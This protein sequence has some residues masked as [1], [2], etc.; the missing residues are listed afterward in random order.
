MIIVI[1]SHIIDKMPDR[2]KNLAQPTGCLSCQQRFLSLDIYRLPFRLLLPDENGMY[3]TFL[4]SMLSLLTIV[5]V[6]IYGAYKTN[7][8]VRKRDYKV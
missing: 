6:I 8:L 5:T 1:I 3:R 7:D 4:G 2:K